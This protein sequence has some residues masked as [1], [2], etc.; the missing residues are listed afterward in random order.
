M[1]MRS[2]SLS[3]DVFQKY[4]ANSPLFPPSLMKSIC[5]RLGSLILGGIII[6]VERL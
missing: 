5:S 4:R 2:E 1:L 6:D 3:Q